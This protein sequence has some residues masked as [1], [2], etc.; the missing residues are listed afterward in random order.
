LVEQEPVLFNDT[1][2]NNVAHGLIGSMYKDLSDE[3]KYQRIKNACEISNADEFIVR[4]HNQYETMVGEGG[5]LLSGG[6][7]QHIAI[8]R[9]IVKDP[10]K[11]FLDEATS[12]LDSQSKKIVQDALNKASKNRTT[13]IVTHRLS[14]IRNATK[15]IV[16]NEGAV[17]EYGSHYELMTKG[18]T[19]YNAQQLQQY[20]EN[21]EVLIQPGNEIIEEHKYESMSSSILTNLKNNY[22]YTTWE[23][24]KKIIKISHP[25]FLIILMGLFVS[26]VNGCIYPIFAVIFSNILQSFTKIDNEQKRDAEFWSLM[27][28]VIAVGTLICNFIQG[29]AFGYSGEK[30]ILRVRS[31]TFASILRQNISFF[32]EEK[33]TTGVLTSE[34]ALNATYLNGLASATLGT[35]LQLCFT[36]FGGLILALIVGWKFALVCMSCI[37]VMIGSGILRIKMLNG[38][39]Q[40]TKKAYER[41]AQ[42]AC[43]SIKNIRT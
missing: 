1:I 10:K 13:I 35:L 43:E 14:T 17:I 41:S 40:K 11:L 4:L 18:S 38:F 16:M 25:E 20:N 12:A 24:I 8:A 33:H 19:Y 23:L 42:F 30:L 15:I 37:P 28:L 26:I 36:V 31:A 2:F 21:S 5:I 6:Q 34:L 39:Q 32:N 27:F 29:T 9:A 7:K 3:V 22:E